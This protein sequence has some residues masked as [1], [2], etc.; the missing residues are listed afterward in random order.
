MFVPL[1]SGSK[2]I[3]SRIIS[4]ICF[5]PFFGGMNFSILSLKNI[6][7]TLSLFCI[8]EKAR[9]AAISAILSFLISPQAPKLRLPLTSTNNMTVSS[10]SSS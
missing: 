5:L 6:T 7:P 2:L 8:E 10:R 4:S 9:V 1:L 3:I